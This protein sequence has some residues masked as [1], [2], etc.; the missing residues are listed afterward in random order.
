MTEA[1]AALA[2]E[3]ELL[4]AKQA[5]LGDLETRLAAAARAEAEAATKGANEIRAAVAATPLARDPAADARR[6]LRERKATL[7]EQWRPA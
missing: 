7:K 6:A 3:K 5:T 1:A 4:A 2:A